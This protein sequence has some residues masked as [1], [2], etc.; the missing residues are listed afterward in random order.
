MNQLKTTASLISISP[1]DRQ[2]CG[3]YR[4][5]QLNTNGK[6]HPPQL[7]RRTGGSARISLTT[8][9]SKCLV[10]VHLCSHT[11]ASAESTHALV[12]I[13]GQRWEDGVAVLRRALSVGDTLSLRDE[14]DSRRSYAFPEPCWEL[15]RQEPKRRTKSNACSRSKGPDP[16]RGQKSTSRHL[17]HL[18]FF[19]GEKGRDRQKANKHQQRFSTCLLCVFLSHSPSP[20]LCT[21]LSRKSLDQMAQAHLSISHLTVS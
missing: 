5:N 8:Y 4:T 7:P 19:P 18:S 10:A 12:E 21:V 1:N 9:Q 17:P 11:G 3:C 13:P 6:T 16:I 14:Q 15:D 2:E 20:L